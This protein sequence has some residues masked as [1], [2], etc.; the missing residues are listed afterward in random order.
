M[1]IRVGTRGSALALTQTNLFIDRFRRHHPGIN[2]EAVS[3]QTTGDKKQGTPLARKGDKRDW[4]YE[5]ELGIVNDTFDVVV[6]SGK[7]IPCDIESGTAMLPILERED[8]RDVF[9]GRKDQS[10][11]KRALIDDAPHG[12]MIGTASLRRRASLLR[13]RPDL[14]VVEHRGNVPTRIEKLDAS[15]ELYGIV[16]AGA[17]VKR[18]SPPGL[19][20]EWID[21]NRMLPAINQ[22]QLVVQFLAARDDVRQAL[23][24]LTDPKSVAAFDAERG[25]VSILKGDCKS[26][27]SIY[28]SVTGADRVAIQVR[29]MLP[30][31]SETLEGEGEDSCAGAFQLGERV[32]QD[33]ISRGAEDLL[34]RSRQ[35]SEQHS[36]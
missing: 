33:L 27:V 22:G 16:L 25:V 17:G 23:M 36:A 13:S 4:I 7:D 32:A 31:G 15:V 29:V 20:W 35:M 21:T 1:K 6:H 28:A 26:S 11:G 9:I 18:L 5:L 3:I 10:T 30:D 24:P 8:A 34:E 12:A 14:R 19:E 2:I